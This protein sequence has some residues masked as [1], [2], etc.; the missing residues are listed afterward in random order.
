MDLFTQALATY[1]GNWWAFSIASDAY[2]P[3]QL[4]KVVEVPT[5][6]YSEE[7]HRHCFLPVEL[8]QRLM[9]GDLVW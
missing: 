3:R 5:L 6:Y 2:D 7:V 8:R 4:R 9:S 1:A